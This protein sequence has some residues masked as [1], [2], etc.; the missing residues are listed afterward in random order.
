MNTLVNNGVVEAYKPLM[1]VEGSYSAQF[2][3][4]SAPLIYTLIQSTNH[5]RQFCCADQTRKSSAAAMTI[6]PSKVLTGA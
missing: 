3:H 5:S 4:V 2:E 1:D 6:E